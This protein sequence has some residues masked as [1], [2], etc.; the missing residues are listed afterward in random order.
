MVVI[1][2]DAPIE[3]FLPKVIESAHSRFPVIGMIS[4]VGGN[5]SWQRISWLTHEKGPQA[6]RH[7]GRP[8]FRCICSRSKR[9]NVLL[10]EFEPAAITWPVV[11][12]CGAAAGLVT[13]EDVLEQIVGRNRG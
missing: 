3:R 4:E 9:L 7:Q 10:K 2:R 12:E 5:Y 1:E 6:F 8:A 13:I 11:D